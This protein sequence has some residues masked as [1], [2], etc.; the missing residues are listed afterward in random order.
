[1]QHL[2]KIIFGL[3]LA[4]SVI[5]VV[6]HG[7]SG[8]NVTKADFDAGTLAEDMKGTKAPKN[9][10]PPVAAAEGALN[11]FVQTV[12]SPPRAGRW[13]FY[14]R[15]TLKGVAKVKPDL[16]KVLDAPA[17]TALR[18]DFTVKLDWASAETTTAKVTAW[19]IYRW[20]GDAKPD[21]TPVAELKPD[22]KSWTDGDAAALAPEAVV[23][24]GVTAMTADET[25]HGK[26][27]SPQSE[28]VT[29]TMPYDRE[30]VYYGASW[31][32]GEGK[33]AEVYVKM[34]HKGGWRGPVRF[35]VNSK[36]VIGKKARTDVDG[37][38]TE[39]DFTTK[40]T[41]ADAGKSSEKRVDDE[42]VE[43]VVEEKW[44]EVTDA[45]GTVT[46][47]LAVKKPKTAG[48]APKPKDPVSKIALELLNQSNAA[49][50]SKDFDEAAR[51]KSLRVWLLRNKAKYWS[52]GRKQKRAEQLEKD[53]HNFGIDILDEQDKKRPN[54]KK[55]KEIQSKIDILKRIESD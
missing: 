42:G 30:L 43:R 53:I 36:E 19:R 11:P 32:A 2:E 21:K 54:L 52:A 8:V 37:A 55:V 16:R 33:A 29:V 44:I 3:I 20:V 26:P 41:L 51:L 24:Y 50:A 23:H 14:R 28:P 4:V 31:K 7:T 46:K 47:I 38:G 15:P 49:R 18:T 6:S 27:E 10:A 45:A 17:L 25:R 13:S 40:W 35:T 34:W 12:A 5:L 9:A 22:V 39:L 48:T 1:M